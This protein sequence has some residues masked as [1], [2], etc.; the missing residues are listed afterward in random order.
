MVNSKALGSFLASVWWSLMTWPNPAA[1]QKWLPER[2]VEFI[3]PAGAGGALDTAM[4]T[5]ERAVRALNALPVSS[6][7]VNR[8]GGE[9]AIAYTY[10]QQ[11]S[12]DPH[13]LSLTAPVLLTNHISGVLP[14]TYT[15]VTP[16]ASLMSEYFLFVVPAESRFK[17]AKDFVE[18][19]RQQPESVSIAGGNLV[20]RITIAKLLQAGEVDIKRVR[21]VTISGAKTSLAVAGGHVDVG[22]AAPGQALTLI[23]SGQLRAIATS[24]PKRLS[25]SLSAVPTWSELG[26]EKAE[27][28]TTRGVIAPKGITAAHILFWEDVLRRAVASEEFRV[29]AEKNHWNAAFMNAAEYRQSLASEYA[30]LKRTMTFTGLVK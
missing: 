27:F 19:L 10:L 28:I 23:Q 14:L 17:T 24:G 4:R 11:R 7:V 18:T 2:H 21:V 12:A 30:N 20:Q 26:Y 25:G 3:V 22:V 1:A 6:G 8:A 16:V 5:L 9:H 15:D 13:F 29:A